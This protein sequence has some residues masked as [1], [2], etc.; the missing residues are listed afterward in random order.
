MRRA[1]RD[2]ILIG[3]GASALAFGV[4]D[5]GLLYGDL[6]RLIEKASNELIALG[7]DAFGQESGEEHEA[8]SAA[9]SQDSELS[10]HWQ[11]KFRNAM[12]ALVD[13]WLDD[14]LRHKCLRDGRRLAEVVTIDD[15][16]EERDGTIRLCLT[17]RGWCAEALESLRGSLGK[18]A[19]TRQEARLTESVVC[20]PYR[21]EIILD[22]NTLEMIARVE[23]AGHTLRS[24][25]CNV[26]GIWS[27]LLTEEEAL[28]DEFAPPEDTWIEFDDAL[29]AQRAFEDAVAMCHETPDLVARTLDDDRAAGEWEWDEQEV[30]LCPKK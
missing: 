21:L 8:E 14:E 3:L 29:R 2:E 23:S 7:Y 5:G 11:F 18:V 17:T 6:A 16:A 12:S 24:C 13:D 19:V 22:E 28:D 27:R 15:I 4:E 9:S 26:N 30:E 10:L 20:G 25:V 1:R